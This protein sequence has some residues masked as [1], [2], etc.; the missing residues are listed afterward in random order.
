[1]KNSKTIGII[2]GMG[3]TATVDIFDKIVRNTQAVTDQEH[4]RILIDNNP[5]IPSRAE[6]I[7]NDGPSPLPTLIK[8]CKDLEKSGADFLIMPCNTATY[9]IKELRESVKIPILDI[10]KESADYTLE[11]YPNI[12]RI[13]ILGTEMTLRL[14]LYQKAF[15]NSIFEQRFNEQHKELMEEL[16]STIREKYTPHTALYLEESNPKIVFENE[17]NAQ[18]ILE[19]PTLSELRKYIMSAIFDKKGIKAGYLKGPRRRVLKILK[20]FQKNDIEAVILGC[21]ELPLVIPEK[22]LYGMHIIDPTEVLAKRAI[23]FAQL[24]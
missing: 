14:G 22:K 10:V 12:K 24:P 11:T 5:K 23:E 2:G 21:T 18:I 17:N 1:M 4:L 19:S 20:D 16:L 6:N 7:L 13:G 9:Y 3:P 8:M 15:I